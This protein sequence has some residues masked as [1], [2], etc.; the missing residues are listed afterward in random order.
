MAV[1][2]GMATIG[3]CAEV[4][5]AP[6]SD[7]LLSGFSRLSGQSTLRGGHDR[8]WRFTARATVARARGC[9]ARECLQHKVTGLPWDSRYEKTVRGNM[10]ALRE[11]SVALGRVLGGDHSR[12][13]VVEAGIGH[14][15]FDL[16]TRR[17]SDRPSA[18]DI[19]SCKPH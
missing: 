4:V 2:F 5:V 9:S 11:L 3:P 14:A 15:R 1:L 10:L 8:H 7:P 16:H 6:D 13:L 18:C 12:M 17:T 19:E